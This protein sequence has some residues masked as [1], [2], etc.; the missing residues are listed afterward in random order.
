[1]RGLPRF[2][3][4]RGGGYFFMPGKDALDYLARSNGGPK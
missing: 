1:M 3:T 2:V 4:V